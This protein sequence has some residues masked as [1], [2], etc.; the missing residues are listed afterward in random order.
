MELL[1]EQL[2]LQWIVMIQHY[3]IQKK[4]FNLETNW[5]IPIDTK[6]IAE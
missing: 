6:E 5:R 1:G 4:V 3:D 2:V